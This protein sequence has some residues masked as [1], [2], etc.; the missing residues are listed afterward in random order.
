MSLIHSEIGQKYKKNWFAF[1]LLIKIKIQCIYNREK[2]V[3]SRYWREQK[4]E[5]IFKK[6]YNHLKAG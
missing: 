1:T 4:A 3:F 5:W 6:I 2:G